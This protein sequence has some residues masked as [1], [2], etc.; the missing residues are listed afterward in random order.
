M[1]AQ[2]LV[3]IRNKDNFPSDR[4]KALKKLISEE[5]HRI[6]LDTSWSPSEPDWWC[7]MMKV[8]RIVCC[9]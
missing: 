5:T 4:W 6:N 3:N 2:L 9:E 7:E 1:D 8:Q